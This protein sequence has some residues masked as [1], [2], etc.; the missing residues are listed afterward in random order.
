MIHNEQVH[1][2]YSK[3]VKKLNVDLG[4]VEKIKRFELVSDEWNI[5][6]GML[7]PTLKV[8]R[9]VVMKH[10]ADLIEKIFS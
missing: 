3:E 8:K 4:E 9:N 7:T 5:G 1:Q 6:N 2:R 10:Y